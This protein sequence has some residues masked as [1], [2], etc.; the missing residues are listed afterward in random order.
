MSRIVAIKI[1]SADLI[2]VDCDR[3]R[4]RRLSDLKCAIRVFECFAHIPD[5]S[6]HCA[7]EFCGAARV[8]SRCFPLT[9]FSIGS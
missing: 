7:F 9:H 2:E 5:P 4:L 6:G 1:G 8:R 3:A